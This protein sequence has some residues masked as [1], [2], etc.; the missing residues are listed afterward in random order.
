[1]PSISLAAYTVRAKKPSTSKYFRV[2]K[3]DH[4]GDLLELVRGFLE[5]LE[6]AASLF[7]DEEERK[8]LTR[9]TR[10]DLKERILAGVLETGDYGYQTELVDVEEQQPPYRRERNQAELFPFAFMFYL[11]KTT[12]Q[13]LMIVQRFE[14]LGI[15]SV[16][17]AHLDSYLEGHWRHPLSVEFNP[18]V[19]DKLID[20]WTRANRAKKIRLVSFKIPKHIETAFQLKGRREVYSE[21]VITAKR[22][23]KKGGS[24]PLSAPLKRLL[25]GDPKSEGFVELQQ[26]YPHDLVKIEVVDLRGKTR[27]VTASKPHNMAA[28][29]DITEQVTIDRTTG[30]PT[31]K[32]LHGEM[33]ALLDL[34]RKKVHSFQPPDVA[35]PRIT[36]EDEE[37]PGVEPSEEPR[38]KAG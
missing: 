12:F 22:K 23:G 20:K 13:G 17:A 24:F 10:L 1:M 3:L 14:N 11:P 35:E 15:R 26:R 16:L 29:V 37:P 18:L 27:T 6:A 9:V 28:Y 36:A 25:K 19:P 33:L 21:L 32:T 5:Q 38:A 31:W 30:H 2:G 8:S 4:N 34:V 7:P